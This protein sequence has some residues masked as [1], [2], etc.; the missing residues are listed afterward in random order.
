M[1]IDLGILD[2]V[3]EGK[4]RPGH[5]KGVATVVDRFFESRTERRVI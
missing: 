3:M 5:F 4:H 2:E 1:S